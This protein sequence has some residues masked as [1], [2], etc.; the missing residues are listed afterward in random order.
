MS[1][2]IAVKGHVTPPK[3]LRKAL[4]LSS[5]DGVDF[6]V[7]RAG[8]VVVHKAVTRAKL[9]APPASTS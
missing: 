7:N 3:K 9:L 8:Q 4:R 1:T 5:G 2:T 6:E